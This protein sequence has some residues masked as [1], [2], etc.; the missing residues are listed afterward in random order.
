MHLP[1]RLIRLLI[2]MTNDNRSMVEGYEDCVVDRQ[3]L[4]RRFGSNVWLIPFEAF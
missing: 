3:M 2:G 4:L 1:Y